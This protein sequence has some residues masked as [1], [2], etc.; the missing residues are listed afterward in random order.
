MKC[1][2][3]DCLKDSS[4]DAI[5]LYHET[6]DQKSGSTSE[7]TATDVVNLAV[8]MK[9]EKTPVY[10]SSLIIRY[11]KLDKKWKEVNELIKKHRLSKHVLFM[12]NE[13]INLVMSIKSGLRN[14]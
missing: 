2:L 12:D 7:D 10:V 3:K 1:L 4:P 8:S 5:I 13:N 11:D 9:N 6:I 14:G